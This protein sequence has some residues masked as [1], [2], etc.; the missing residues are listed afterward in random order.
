MIEYYITSNGKFLRKQ[1]SRDLDSAI[2]EASV[3]FFAYGQV[4]IWEGNK[5]VYELPKRNEIKQNINMEAR[6]NNMTSKENYDYALLKVSDD[7]LRVE[8]D[9]ELFSEKIKSITEET[10]GKIV[11]AKYKSKYNDYIEYDYPP[12]AICGF[13]YEAKVIFNNKTKRDYACYLLENSFRTIS[14][15]EK[16]LKV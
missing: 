2:R 16:L 11:E 7:C 10:E 9:A 5:I 8:A 1:K 13:D 6:K 12:F 15:L 4:T 3:T 14:Q